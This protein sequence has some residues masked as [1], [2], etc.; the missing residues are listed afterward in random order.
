MINE[1]LILLYDSQKILRQK[2]TTKFKS[3]KIKMWN[4]SYTPDYFSLTDIL[5]EQERVPVVTNED[6]PKLGFLDPSTSSRSGTLAQGTK[7]ELPLWMAKS[8][9]RKNQA[10]ISMPPSFTEKKR[11]IVF[12]DPDAVNLHQYGPHYYESGRHLMKLGTQDAE[13]IGK[14]L[15]ETMTKRFR[16]IMDSSSNSSECD[17]LTKTERLDSLEKLLYKQGQKSMKLQETWS[18]RK[19]GQLKV[20]TMVH[21]HNK[22]KAAIMS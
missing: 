14:L 12:A 8:L 6:L 16:R 20:A 10:S 7:M 2:Q 13:D 5:A 17:T 1:F 3:P 15:V 19:T 21:R 9:M 11:Q 4:P 18:K 22:R